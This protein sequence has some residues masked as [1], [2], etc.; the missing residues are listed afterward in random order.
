MKTEKG[1]IA[2]L[3]MMSAVNAVPRMA[4]TNTDGL[5]IVPIKEL[6]SRSGCRHGLS[7][8]NGNNNGRRIG[9]VFLHLLFELPKRRGLGFGQVRCVVPTYGLR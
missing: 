8:V 6:G 7:D 9:E 4:G 1:F 5:G 3:E 2:S